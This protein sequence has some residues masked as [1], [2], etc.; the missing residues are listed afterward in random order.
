MSSSIQDIYDRIDQSQK[1]Q[2]QQQRLEVANQVAPDYDRATRIF[3]VEANTNLPYDVVDADLENLEDQLKR[4][5]FDADQYKDA[6]NGAPVFNE[7]AAAHPYH[8]AVLERD[9]QNLTRLERALNPIFLGW[10]SGWAMTEMAEIR[11]RQLSNFENPDNEAD[12]ARLDELRKFTEGGMFGA[13]TWYEKLLVGTA[14]QLP[15]Q[16]WLIGESLDEIAIGAATYGGVAAVAGQLGPQALIPEEVVT[17]PAAMAMG[18]KHGF[19]VGRSEAAFRLERGLAYDQ[20]LELG[21]DEEEARWASTAVGGV[22]AVLESIGLGALTKRIPGFKQVMDD[23]VGGV[24]NSVLTKPTFRQAAA[25][26]SLQYGEGVA[27]E[28]VTEVLQE[29]TLIAAQELLKANARERGDIREETRQ[30][31]SGEF[32]D[33]VGEIAVHTMYGV[34]LIGGVGPGASFY[35]D[36]KRAYQARRLGSAWQAMGEA[37]TDSETRQNSPSKYREFVEALTGKH[38][39]VMM[40]ARR[41]IEY[42]QEQGMDPE[43]VAISVGISAEELGAAEVGGLDVEIPVGQYLEKLAISEHHNALAKDLKSHPDQMSMNEAEAFEKNMDQTLKEINELA[44]ELDPVAAAEDA[45]IVETVK[46]QLIEAGTEPSAAENQAQIMVGI[47]NLAR[48]TNQDPATFFQERFGGVVGTTNAQMNVAKDEVDVFVD[49]YLDR[50]RAGDLPQQRDIFGP[51]IV[52]R[53]KALGGL[54]PDAELDARDIKMQVRGLIKESGE[55]LDGIAEFLHDEGYIP[56]RDPNLVLEALEREL[57]GDLVFGSQFTVKQDQQELLGQLEQLASILDQYG[58][59]IADMS[60]AEVREALAQIESHYQTDDTI[61]TTE[62]DELTE[63][64]FTV[65]EHDPAMLAR[66]AALLPMLSPVQEFGDVKFTKDYTLEDGTKV[67]RK[68]A[69]NREFEQASKRKNVLQKLKEC[70]GG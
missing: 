68:R 4:Q 5:T 59:D 13:D 70:L 22:N 60:N 3:A 30:I 24:I 12:K 20:Y 16:G 64:V 11:N 46:Q 51:S 61:D 21:L 63:L 41:F 17:V 29:S 10:D 62:L 1:E 55:T 28:L 2:R 53:M 47:P 45:K 56:A 65:A 66:A 18:A 48:R 54:A 42:F 34:G 37:A 49:P 14:Q 44:A 32:W 67:T 40:E 38:G 50:I 23:R 43:E 15:I 25:R 36:S 9:R 57:S 19:L 8:V 31:T 27:T 39:K 69:A 33:Q 7:F 6:I 26:A 52:D 35:A 58:I